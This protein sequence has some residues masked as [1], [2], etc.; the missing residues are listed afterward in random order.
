ME[1]T[2]DRARKY[3]E[4]SYTLRKLM[5]NAT[6]KQRAEDWDQILVVKKDDAQ[7]ERNQRNGLVPEDKQMGDDGEECCVFDLFRNVMS[8]EDVESL[9][10]QA[11]ATGQDHQGYQSFTLNWST[12]DPDPMPV[13]G[14][15]L[16][17]VLVVAPLMAPALQE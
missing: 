13:D 11:N 17:G 15:T 7:E 12:T 1:S 9:Y 4:T 2:K 3:Y 6:K 5:D 8:E 16:L 14:E 10:H